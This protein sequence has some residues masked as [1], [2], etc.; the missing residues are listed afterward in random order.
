M[1]QAY[2]TLDLMGAMEADSG[3][4]PEVIRADGGLVANGF[5]CEFLA[6][7]LDKPVEIP[8]VVETTA[9]GAACL[10]GLY[11]GVFKGLDNIAQNWVCE[12]RYE[13]KLSREK[14]NRLYTGWKDAVN[15]ITRVA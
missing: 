12:N 8:K 4:K 11:S 6:D 5:M 7:M 13:P 2:Q 14:R 10:A 3:V 9:W 1:Q 15:M